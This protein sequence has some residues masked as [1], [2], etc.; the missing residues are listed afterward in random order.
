MVS[1]EVRLAQAAVWVRDV[2]NV[3]PGP[4]GAR[5]GGVVRFPGQRLEQ[6]IPPDLDVCRREGR[7][8][9][10][11]PAEHDVLPRRLE[12][13]VHDLERSRAVVAQDGLR[14]EPGH[15]DLRDVGADDR[16]L[17]AV[18]QNAPKAVRLR[19]SADAR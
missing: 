3:L 5:E 19:L 4:W 8:L 13:V 11:G 2:E 16:A 6:M 15:V 12:M 10:I 18:Q 9:R 17:C 7:G 14:V 1:A